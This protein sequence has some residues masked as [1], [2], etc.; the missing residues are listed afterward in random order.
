[1]VDVW[2]QESVYIVGVKRFDHTII[3]NE[4]LRWF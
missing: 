4:I 2:K 3:V 1:V